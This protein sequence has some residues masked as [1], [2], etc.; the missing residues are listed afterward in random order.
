MKEHPLLLDCSACRA[1]REWVRVQ[2]NVVD[3]ATCGK[4]HSDDSLMV[5]DPEVQYARDEQG[6]LLEVPP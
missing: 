5:A 4:R 2:E 1:F 3:C 6:D